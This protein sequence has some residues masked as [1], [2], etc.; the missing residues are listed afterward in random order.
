[1]S[2]VVVTPLPGARLLTPPTISLSQRVVLTVLW[3]FAALTLVLGQVAA[4]LG[5]LAASGVL[6]GFLAWRRRQWPAA[7]SPVSASPAGLSIG[8]R[9][10]FASH[11]LVRGFV[12]TQSGDTEVMLHHRQLHAVRLAV[13]GPAEGVALLHALGLGASQRVMAFPT[14]AT[15]LHRGAVLAGLVLGAGAVAEVWW[16]L[17]GVF[18]AL[19]AVLLC[20]VGLIVVG[21]PQQVTV[22]LDALDLRWWWRRRTIPLGAITAVRVDDGGLWIDQ[23]AEP[24]LWIG[25]RWAAGPVAEG[26]DPARSRRTWAEA[27]GARIEEAR[28]VAATRQSP[29]DVT[30]LRRHDRDLAAWRADLQALGAPAPQHYRTAGLRVEDLW[31]AVES[32]A[33]EAELRVAAAVALGPGLDAQG[34]ARMAQAAETAAT[35]QVRF[36]LDAVAAGDEAAEV[37]ALASAAR[38]ARGG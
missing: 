20:A 8:D 34:C 17:F 4:G 9:L 19:G 31:D 30:P 5:I 27:L 1:M 37:R 2:P 3:I 15:A 14:D 10:A 7:A 21:F 22:G 36:A 25:T 24:P 32:P 6:A 11:D 23:A 33:A 35:P 26:F 29:A 28:A 38:R 16:P 18:A 13:S 12:V